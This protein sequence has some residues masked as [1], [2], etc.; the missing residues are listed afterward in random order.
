MRFDYY[1]AALVS[2]FGIALSLESKFDPI[3][4]PAKGETIHAGTVYTIEWDT[5][6]QG[7]SG[8]IDLMLENGEFSDNTEWLEVISTSTDGSDGKF[9]WNISSALPTGDKYYIKV[10]NINNYAIFNESPL[11]KIKASNESTNATATSSTVVIIGPATTLPT[12]SN[13]TATHSGSAATSTSS[14]DG[15]MATPIVAAPFALVVGVVVV[16]M[17]S[18]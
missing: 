17:M 14:G 9:R 12:M 7:H 11:F 10:G 5:S 16:G 2:L 8:P 1:A 3:T 15:S 6:N 4:R 18:F 13:G